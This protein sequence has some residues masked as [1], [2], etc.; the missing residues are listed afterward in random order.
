MKRIG[1]ISL[2]VALLIPASAAA[3]V[4]AKQISVPDCAPIA[5]AARVSGTVD[6]K[7]T[8][9]SRGQVASVDA[10][11]SS[12]M[13]VETAK[14]NMRD[15]IFCEPKKN[16]SAHVQLRFEYRL[17]GVPAYPVPHAMVIIDLGTG[18]VVIT[19][20]PAEVEP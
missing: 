10:S 20:H 8:V 4:C 12:P 9:G 15:W 6:L 7:I 13:L 5:L 11:G 2:I 1:N 17:E 19:S 18:T 16:R 14:E 3:Q